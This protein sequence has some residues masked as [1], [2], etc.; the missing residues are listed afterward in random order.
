MN[1]VAGRVQQT[2]LEEWLRRSG[3]TGP[4]IFVN[5]RLQGNDADFD[6]RV[7]RVGKELS[8]G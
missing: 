5:P 8:P 7:I 6:Y 2:M 1:E 4:P 3:M